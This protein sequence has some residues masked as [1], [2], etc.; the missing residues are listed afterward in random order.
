MSISADHQ[1]NGQQLSRLWLAII[2]NESATLIL[3]TICYAHSQRNDN[4]VYAMHTHGRH[5]FLFCRRFLKI[6]TPMLT[7]LLN[8]RGMMDGPWKDD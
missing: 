7:W 3:M 8:T 5:F 4:I 1:P 2:S 6:M